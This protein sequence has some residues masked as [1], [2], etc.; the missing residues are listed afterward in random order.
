[1]IVVKAFIERDFQGR[2]SLKGLA[3]IFEQLGNGCAE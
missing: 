2:L 3:E 1:M